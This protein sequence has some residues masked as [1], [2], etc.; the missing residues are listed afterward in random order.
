VL[1]IIILIKSSPL[2]LTR[3]ILH[4]IYIIHICIHSTHT[5]VYICNYISYIIC[6]TRLRDPNIPM[7]VNG[8]YYY[9]YHHH[10]SPRGCVFFL[11]RRR[12]TAKPDCAPAAPRTVMSTG[13]VCSQIP[14]N[15]LSYVFCRLPIDH[16]TNNIVAIMYE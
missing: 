9:Y 10:P 3:Y 4:T 11:F 12:T 16:N 8:L 2:R 14:N 1:F 13:R 15:V 5:R 7:T 6:I